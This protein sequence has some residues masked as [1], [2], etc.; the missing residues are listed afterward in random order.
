MDE[1]VI[2]IGI[3]ANPYDV[4]LSSG[5]DMSMYSDATI[6]FMQDFDWGGFF[7]SPIGQAS[8][9]WDEFLFNPSVS[10]SLVPLPSDPYSV[11]LPTPGGFDTISISSSPYR[12]QATD[13]SVLDSVPSP[14]SPSIYP[15]PPSLVPSSSSPL[16][17]DTSSAAGRSAAESGA[18]GI[19]EK[20]AA[21]IQNT[22]LKAAATAAQVY[23]QKALAG[24]T[25]MTPQQQQQ[26][27]T[28]EL[29]RQRQQQYAAEYA[30]AQA[31]AAAQA[32]QGTGG[33]PISPVMIIGAVA[34]LV[35]V[36]GGK[37][38]RK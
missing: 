3:N 4:L 21:T 36:G 14:S 2:D 25:G 7:T 19:M 17:V 10:P 37:K 12:P 35:F 24:M 28:S 23:A 32:G 1:F 34:L 5:A 30:A 11:P 27:A 29:L 6:G 8:Y 15:A 31:S 38:G 26:Y 16:S 20:F 33:A 9:S 18:A 22:I 13:G